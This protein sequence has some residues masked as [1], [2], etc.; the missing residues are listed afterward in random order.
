MKLLD[1][2]NGESLKF[3]ICPQD[4]ASVASTV[5]SSGSGKTY[6]GRLSYAMVG[7]MR[8][9][10]ASNSWPEI[11]SWTQNDIHAVGGIEGSTSMCKIQDHSGTLL[12]TGGRRI[13]PN[14]PTSLGSGWYSLVGDAT[15]I[16]VFP[17][18]RANG[19]FCD[20]HVETITRGSGVGTG[21][22]GMVWEDAHGIWTTKA[23]D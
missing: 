5:V 18:G 20:G 16:N 6:T 12:V 17:R 13:D 14:D 8:L 19:V 22:Q 10:H 1:L 15:D 23:G 9:G 11:I 3:L 4:K 7:G 2:L 21:T